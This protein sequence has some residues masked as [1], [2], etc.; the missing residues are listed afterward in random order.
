[1]LG[2]QRKVAEVSVRQLCLNETMRLP[3]ENKVANELRMVESQGRMQLLPPVIP[4]TQE[5][6]IRRI[7]V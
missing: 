3:V 4:D 2:E 5:V 7:L 6:E 1:M